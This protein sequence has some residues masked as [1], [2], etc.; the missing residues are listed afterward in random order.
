MA[1]PRVRTWLAALASAALAVGA[2]GAPSLAGSSHRASGPPIPVGFMGPFTGFISFDGPDELTGV[3]AAVAEINAA[4]GVLGRPLQVFQADS[5]SDPVDAVPAFRKLLSVDHIVAEF[6]PTS[7]AGPALIPI[8]T[9]AQ[10]PIF[11]QGGTTALNHETDPYF[12][13][14]TPADSVQGTAM[15][16]W[17]IHEHWMTAALVFT[18]ASSAQTL[19]API[20]QAYQRHGGKIL[21]NIAVVPQASSYRS[22]VLRLVQAKPQVVFY[23][24]DP[25]TAGTFFSEV[26][27]LGFDAQTHWIGSNIESTT[28]V[29]KAVGAKTATTN[30]Y[31][32]NGALEND[33]AATVFNTWNKKV[34]HLSAPANLAP[35]EYDAVIVAALA[36]DLAGTTK[37]SVWVKDVTR[38]SNPPGIPVYSYAQGLKLLREGKKINYQGAASTVDFNQWHNV[39]GPFSVYV[40]GPNEQ[41]KAIAT[42][43]DTALEKF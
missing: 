9:K 4:G 25:Q 40:W 14:T 43:P 13:R 7:N 1:H 42:I 22:E 11:I 28:D 20:E 29:Y 35:E 27:Q 24:L 31:M 38:V 3:K 17:A 18:T 15:A 37:G 33:P 5:A 26:N 32:T 10:V 21:A 16:Y 34:N 6:G 39:V 41:L 23:Q 12:F 36:M 2:V 19:V 8:A 30:N